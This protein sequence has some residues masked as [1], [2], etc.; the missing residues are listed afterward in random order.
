MPV[1]EFYNAEQVG[2][3]YEPNVEAVVRAGRAAKL[4]PSSE[5]RETTLLLLV[6][7]QVDFVHEDGAL[8]VPGAVDDMRRLVEWMYANMGGIT[9]IAA[10][11]D[12]HY[13]I[14]VFTPTWWV[15]R[16]GEYPQPHTVITSDDVRRE[17]WRPVYEPEWSR[18]YVETLESESKKQL[19]I[20][21]Y[22]TLIG[23]PGHSLTPAIYEAIAYHSAARQT[24]PEFIEKGKI[25]KTEYYSLFEPEVKVPDEPGGELNEAFMREVAGYNRVYI[26]GQAKSHCV[27]E[28]VTSIMRYF[29]LQPAVIDRFFVLMDAT[30]AVAHPEIDFDK[31]AEAALRG[32]ESD[33]LHLTT[34]GQAS[35]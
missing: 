35:L 3:L 21:P 32:F 18:A 24:Q 4:T 30:S 2:Q 14:Q 22:H 20:W 28:S 7:A 19:M 33:G 16:D 11:L 25:A 27:L 6:D 26:A 17:R 5:D 1:P 13:P 15:N 12:S 29:E 23:T 34:T 31:M 9:K 10:S 8:S